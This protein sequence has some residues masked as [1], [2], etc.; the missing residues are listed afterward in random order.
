MAGEYGCG[1]E[2]LMTGK[3]STAGTQKTPKEL[4]KTRK[5]SEGFLLRLFCVFAFLF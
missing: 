5:N 2:R 3:T 1:G 4:Q